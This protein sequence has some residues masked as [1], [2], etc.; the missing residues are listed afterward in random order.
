M[1]PKQWCLRQSNKFS[2]M[3]LGGG[4]VICVRG[5]PGHFVSGKT[6]EEA[7]RNA[8]SNLRSNHDVLKSL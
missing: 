8:F 2:A 5:R 4:W 1:T 6:E 7:W 3:P